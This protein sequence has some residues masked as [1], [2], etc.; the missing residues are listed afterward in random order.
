VP[1]RKLLWTDFAHRLIK[2]P[3]G[4][5]LNLHTSASPVEAPG[6]LSFFPEGGKALLEHAAHQQ[7]CTTGWETRKEAMEATQ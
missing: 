6:S 1:Q 2:A 7:E 4:A 3:V 5:G